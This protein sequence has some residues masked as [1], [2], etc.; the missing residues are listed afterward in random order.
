MR[1]KVERRG[2]PR[3]NRDLEP[4]GESGHSTG[5]LEALQRRVGCMYLSDLLSR[6]N[7]PF[8]RHADG[9]IDAEKYGADEWNDA[10][11]YIIV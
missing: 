11:R 8:V 3:K 10:V 9:K 7:T 1:T 5:L 2:R 6:S 4:S